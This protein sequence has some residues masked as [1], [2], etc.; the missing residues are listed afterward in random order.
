MLNIGSFFTRQNK[1]LL[2]F[3]HQG[4]DMFDDVYFP[5]W[6]QLDCDY[7][8]R[9]L[10]ISEIDWKDTGS[11]T[12]SHVTLGKSLTPPWEALFI[13]WHHCDWTRRP[14]SKRSGLLLPSIWCC[15][16]IGLTLRME[17]EIGMPA[18]AQQLEFLHQALV[19]HSH[20]WASE[21]IL[22]TLCPK[23]GL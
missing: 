12:N 15:D 3:A 9:R 21:V 4:R 17:R 6:P 23:K 2:C 20:L 1:L 8:S 7:R 14:L 16:S 11:A 18:K 19:T 22:D 10:S 13:N 5:S